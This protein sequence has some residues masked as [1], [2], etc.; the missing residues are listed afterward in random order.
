[1]TLKQVQVGELGFTPPRS[2]Q[3]E[4]VRGTRRAAECFPP[5]YKILGHDVPF[6]QKIN[7][8]LKI[9]FFKI[10]PSPEVSPGSLKAPLCFSVLLYVRRETEEVFDAL[11]LKTPDLKGLR[12][13]VRALRTPPC[14]GCLPGLCSCAHRCSLLTVSVLTSYRKAL[15]RNILKPMWGACRAGWRGC[16]SA[17]LSPGQNPGSTLGVTQTINPP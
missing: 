12:N 17:M 1:M 7:F 13:A 8:M 15:G 4:Q 9:V 16:A 14:P 2:A 10:L 5:G 3:S 6:L 11:M